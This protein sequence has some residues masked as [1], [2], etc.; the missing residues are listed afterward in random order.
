MAIK[1][2]YGEEIP[3]TTINKGSAGSFKPAEEIKTADGRVV[4]RWLPPKR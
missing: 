4:T 3:F 1:R 2:G